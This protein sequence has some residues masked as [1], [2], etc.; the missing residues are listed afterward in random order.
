LYATFGTCFEE[1]ELA[2]ISLNGLNKAD[3]LAALYNA[4]KPQ[5]MG[6]MQYD[7]KPMTRDEAET[8]LKRGTYFD[9]LKGRV[10]K[11]E[12]SGDELNEWGYDRDNGQGAAERALAELRKTGDAN[13]PAISS[14]HHE[15][16]LASARATKARLHEESRVEKRDSVTT[17]RL[18]LADVAE[19]LNAAVGKAVRSQS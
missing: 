2:M 1:K 12:L 10:M 19:P 15:N 5:G 6:F 7:S 3:V 13:T 17:F 4:S 14:T 16:T 8:L 11:V 18:G 9:Y